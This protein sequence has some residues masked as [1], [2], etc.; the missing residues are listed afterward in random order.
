ML[1]LRYL[2][3]IAKI[4]EVPEKTIVDRIPGTQLTVD[5]AVF[6]VR[7]RGVLLDEYFMPDIDAAFATIS[8]DVTLHIEQKGDVLHISIARDM[9]AARMVV[10]S[11]K[12]AREVFASFVTD[13]ARAHLYPQIRD[14]VPS[15]TRQ[16]RDAL[17]RRLKE[18]EELFRYEL[19]DFGAIES[20]LADYLAGKA[21]LEQVLRSSGGS[22]SGQRQE[23]RV[24]QVGTVEM[25]LPD[26]LESPGESP[27]GSAYDAVPPI[28]R[29]EL[30]SNM[31]VLTVAAENSRLNGFQMFLAM[32][33]RLAKIE[34][35]FLHQPHTTKLMWGS[36]RVI[37]VFTNATG[38]LSL[39]YDIK[40]K[41][42]LETQTTGGAM[43]PTTTIVTKDRVF[44]PVPKVLEPAFRIT[45]GAK[46]FFVRFDTIP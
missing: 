23:L 13:F 39:Y 2:K 32:S 4:D 26:I 45:D 3:E 5:E 12:S 38:E 16:G 15:S 27:S 11:Y 1:Q 25:E 10:E 37:F 20:L 6:L 42:P 29:L 46:E 30:T 24:E 19:S 34:G 8:H 9:Q 44:I 28:L 18:N 41:E 40:L 22:G 21:D 14:H 36:H 31:K 7:L 43:F 35:D 33:D 17:Y